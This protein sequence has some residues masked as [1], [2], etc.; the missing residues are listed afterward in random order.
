[1]AALSK[2]KYHEEVLA[3]FHTL[4]QTVNRSKSRKNYATT[5]KLLY[6]LRL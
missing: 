6:N 1:M 4:R 2:L 3:I 5:A